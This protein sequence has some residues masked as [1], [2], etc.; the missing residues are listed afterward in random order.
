MKLFSSIAIYDVCVVS[1][2]SEQAREALLAAIADGAKPT[3]ITA[4]EIVRESAIRSGFRE[5]R[6]FVAADISDVDF[7]KCKGKTTAEIFAQIY[8]KQRGKS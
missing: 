7:N 4:T 8:T 2:S 3:E 5:E 1:D 6:P